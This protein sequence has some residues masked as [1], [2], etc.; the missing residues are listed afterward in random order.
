MQLDPIKIDFNVTENYLGRVAAGQTI[1]VT[2]DAFPGA[3]FD[4]AVTAVDA[5]VDAKSRNVALR[6]ELANPEMKLRPGLFARVGLELGRRENALV[7]PEQALWPQGNKQNVYVVQDGKANLVE[8]TT[9]IRRDGKVELLSGV[10]PDSL[11]IV[12]GQLKIMMPGQPV[13]PVGATPANA[14]ASKPAAPTPQKP[15]G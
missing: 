4:G 11:V 9:G 1:R 15:Q 7:V 6:G 13:A 8:V 14:A 3:T 12:A 10:T 5:G 2:L